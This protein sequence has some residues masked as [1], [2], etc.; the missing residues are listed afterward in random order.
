MCRHAAG[1][2]SLKSI[3]RLWDLSDEC[4]HPEDDHV[5]IEVN[6]FAPY[7]A[8]FIL[9]IGGHNLLIEHKS[10][11]ASRQQDGRIRLVTRHSTPNEDA[12]PFDGRRQWHFLIWHP[13]LEQDEWLC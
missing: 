4:Q 11:A 3:V 6:E 7:I 2:R 5:E 10:G 1:E 8:D 13:F 9:R 12:D